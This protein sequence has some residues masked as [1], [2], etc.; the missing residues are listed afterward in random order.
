MSDDQS[1]LAAFLQ[2]GLPK[3]ESA[4]TRALRDGHSLAEL[5]VVLQRAI[6]GKVTGGCAPREAVVRRFSDDPAIPRAD[7]DRI[8]SFVRETSADQ[9][10]VVLTIAREGYTAFAV[11]RLEGDVIAPPKADKPN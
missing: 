8:A 6:D 2:E 3:I 1:V 5:A 11:Q 7:G 4:V 10:P 9:L